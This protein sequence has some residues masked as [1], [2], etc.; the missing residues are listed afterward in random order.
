MS[1]ADVMDVACAVFNLSRGA[2]FGAAFLH[3]KCLLCFR[4]ELRCG[5]EPFFAH[6]RVTPFTRVLVSHS[7]S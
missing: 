6:T 5:S 2:K 7:G 3:R 1:A 4:L